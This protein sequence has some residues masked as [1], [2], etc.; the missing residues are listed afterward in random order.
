MKVLSLDSYF[1]LSRKLIYFLISLLS[2]FLGGV[3]S[4]IDF[5]FF[6]FLT[7]N[8]AS[9]FACFC[10]SNARF[11]IL[12]LEIEQEISVADNRIKGK[13]G[14]FMFFLNIIKKREAKKLLFLFFNRLIILKQQIFLFL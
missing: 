11:D 1:R 3:E 13:K 7:F 8:L 14:F 10:F 12:S 5:I 4:D 2:F 6:V 9:I